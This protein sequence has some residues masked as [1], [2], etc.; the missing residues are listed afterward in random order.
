MSSYIPKMT[1]KVELQRKVYFF[2]A[3]NSI[4]IIGFLTTFKLACDTNNIHEG[5]AMWVV[6]YLLMKFADDQVIAE[7]GPKTLGYTQ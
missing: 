4:S 3:S 5:A 6:N 7:M 1:N 2:G